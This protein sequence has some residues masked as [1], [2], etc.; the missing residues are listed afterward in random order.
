MAIDFRLNELWN[1]GYTYW[2]KPKVSQRTPDA[3]LMIHP[4][5]ATSRKIKDGA[6]V[7]L[8]S[9]YGKCQ[10]KARVTTDVKRGIVGIPALFPKPGQEFNYATSSAVSPVNG[11]FVTMVACQVTTS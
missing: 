5:D 4:D 3:F 6:W 9:P 1:T 2:D 7:T 10:A 11:D 8:K